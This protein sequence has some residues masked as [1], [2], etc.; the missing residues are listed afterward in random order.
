MMVV[1]VSA[2]PVGVLAIASALAVEGSSDRAQGAVAA[3][4]QLVPLVLIYPISWVA[5][6]VATL[7]ILHKD[8]PTMSLAF[9]PVGV[10]FWPMAAVLV[11]YTLGVVGGWIA[12]I[13]P[14]LFL[15]VVWLFAPQ[16]AVLEGLGAT[17]SLSRSADL[18]RGGWW[19]CFATIL[20]LE[21][22]T[23]AVIVGALL[24]LG[25]AVDGLSNDAQIVVSG[26]ASILLTALV[27]PFQVIGIALLYL[28]RRVRRE[29]AWPTIPRSAYEG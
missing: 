7:A 5:G 1:L 13:L 19:S 11:I 17:R 18:V 25:L 15:L 2:L 29:G 20:V 14:G 10:R 4:I 16:A 8:R 26:A 9:H 27:K 22:L 12:F 24:L 23:S 3:L 21:L 6:T 28:D